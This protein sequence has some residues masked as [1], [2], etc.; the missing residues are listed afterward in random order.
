MRAISAGAR[1]AA[2]VDGSGLWGVGGDMADEL[3][4]WLRPRWPMWVSRVCPLCHVDRGPCLVVLERLEH[5][6]E[7]AVDRV[8]SGVYLRTLLSLR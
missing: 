5:A 3:G 8:D 6:D 7:R 4:R 1:L 2:G